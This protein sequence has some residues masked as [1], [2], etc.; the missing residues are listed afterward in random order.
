MS[1]KI[2]TLLGKSQ[3]KVGHRFIYEGSAEKC[4]D[5]PYLKVCHG[6]L[7][8]GTVYRVVEVRGRK[9]ECLLLGEAFLVRVEPAEV[10]AAVE[11]RQAIQG[12]TVR[13]SPRDCGKMECQYYIYCS[14]PA[15]NL[16]EKPC[17]ILKIIRSFSCPQTG[18]Q[19]SLVQLLPQQA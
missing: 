18:I 15:L 12:A 7:K 4:E 1:S 16:E 8:K 5:C 9:V 17:K 6:K 10:E 11:A 14:P 19:L 3:A 13:F 2:F